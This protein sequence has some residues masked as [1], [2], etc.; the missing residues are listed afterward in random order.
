MRAREYAGPLGVLIA[1]VI[2]FS[3]IC[4]VS[5]MAM[6]DLSNHV[7]V[8]EA[9]WNIIDLAVSNLNTAV[10]LTQQAVTAFVSTSTPMVLPTKTAP[11]TSTVVPSDTPVRF[12]TVTPT[13]PRRTRP[14]STSLAPTRTRKPNPTATPVPPTDTPVPPPT[15]TPLPPPTDIPPTDIPPTDIPPTDI[16]PTDIPPTNIPPTDVP[17]TAQS[18]VVTDV[19]PTP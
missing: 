3:L 5:A 11:P 6:S 17:P 14:E 10:A 19:A 15:D 9:P 16:P 2:G 13:L 4:S 18:S 8:T 7:S 1:G 12:V